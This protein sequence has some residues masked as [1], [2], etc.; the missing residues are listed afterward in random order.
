MSRLL[1]GLLGAVIGAVV[2]VRQGWRYGVEAVTELE[3]VPTDGETGPKFDAE[4]NDLGG[5]TLTCWGGSELES[6]V[7]KMTFERAETGEA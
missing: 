5:I 1:G 7:A 3:Q 6:R 2:G 4:L